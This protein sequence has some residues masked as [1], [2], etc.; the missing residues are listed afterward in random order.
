MV[1]LLSVPESDAPINSFIELEKDDADLLIIE[2]F[3]SE[4][5][6]NNALEMKKGYV[7]ALSLNSNNPELIFKNAIKSDVVKKLLEYTELYLI[8][9][10]V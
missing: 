6:L 8:A 5:A 10:Q 7:A 4:D 3:V 2:S 9:I 1:D